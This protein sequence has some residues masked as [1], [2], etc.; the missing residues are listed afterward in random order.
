MANLRILYRNLADSATITTTGTAAGYPATNLQT[1]TKGLVWRSTSTSAT[2]ITVAWA[3]DQTI[4]C[5]FL[6]FT[7]LTT[8][9]TIRVVLKTS[10]GTSI[11]DSGTVSAVPYSL[12]TWTTTTN[13][14]M[15]SYGLGTSVRIYTSN[16]TTVRSMEITLVDGSNTQGYMEVSRILC[17]SYWGLTY[18]VEYG[19]DVSYNDRSSSTRSQ[20]GNLIIDNGT[21]SKS[22]SFSLGYMSTTD[23]NLLIQLF[24]Q[25]GTKRPLMVSLFPADSD[26]E[27]EA[28][29]EIYGILQ[30]SGTISHPVYSQYTSSIKIEEI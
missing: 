7:N 25:H 24:R 27:K 16:Q 30:D 19:L 11:Y 29:Y 3:S 8:T 4:N 26:K 1:D 15:Y 12:S 23:R 28:V 21:V 2:T 17:G 20:N 5:V 10:G 14:N 9:S 6:P 13:S 18:N 22:I